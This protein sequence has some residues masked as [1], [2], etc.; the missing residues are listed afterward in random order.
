MKR[1]LCALFTAAF[2]LGCQSVKQGPARPVS[3][4]TPVPVYAADPVDF[5]EAPA[6]KMIPAAQH[7]VN[8]GTAPNN[9]TGDTLRDAFG[10]VNGDITELYGSVTGAATT[11]P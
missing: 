5:L 7:P 2:F 3:I 10:K 9:G 4:P 11:V 6:G 1:L 8:V